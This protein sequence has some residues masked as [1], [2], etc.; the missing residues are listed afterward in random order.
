M[1]QPFDRTKIF[2]ASSGF[3]SKFFAGSLGRSAS[4]SQT[5]RAGPL[6]SG[7]RRRLPSSSTSS[8]PQ[9]RPLGSNLP[10]SGLPFEP[11]PSPSAR[12]QRSEHPVQTMRSVGA[13]PSELCVG[14]AGVRAAGARAA[15]V[16]VGARAAGV[17]LL[18]QELCVGAAAAEPA[19]ESRRGRSRFTGVPPAFSADL[20]CTD[21][22]VLFLSH[23]DLFCAD[24][25]SSAPASPA[26][27]NKS[28]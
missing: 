2:T 7:L 1:G 13:P 23:V 6:E 17:R 9:I 27:H 10:Q 19:S 4:A 11:R 12:V 22:N 14:A 25:L 3:L 26:A 15:G 20:A 21:E 5:L 8:P 18:G 28:T 16:R 24:H